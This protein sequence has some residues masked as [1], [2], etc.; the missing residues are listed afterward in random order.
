MAKEEDVLSV[1]NKYYNSHFLLRIRMFSN[2]QEVFITKDADEKLVMHFN[3]SPDSDKKMI[4]NSVAAKMQKVLVDKKKSYSFHRILRSWHDQHFPIYDL[5]FQ[6][7]ESLKSFLDSKEEAERDMLQAVVSLWDPAQPRPVI[8]LEALLYLMHPQKDRPQ[9]F[10]VTQG[11]YETLL[12][13][14]KD[15]YLFNFEEKIFQSPCTKGNTSNY[16]W[17][18]ILNCTVILSSDTHPSGSDE[19]VEGCR[20]LVLPGVLLGR[21]T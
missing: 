9:M 11:N 6:S 15:S 14:F 13:N 7:A 10:Q 18:G 4:L 19:G 1:Y 2:D 21:K 8:K 17:R 16:L 3:L 5:Y 20:E 12:D